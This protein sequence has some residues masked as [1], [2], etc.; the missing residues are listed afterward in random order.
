ME[1]L[2]AVAT[3]LG[4]IAAVWYFWDKGAERWV[5]R[6]APAAGAAAAPAQTAPAPRSGIAAVLHAELR[7]FGVLMGE[8]VAAARAAV[9]RGR[10]VLRAAMTEFGGRLAPAAADAILAVFDDAARC[11]ACAVAA[12]AALARANAVLPPAERVHYRFGIDLREGAAADGSPPRAAVERAA[13]IGLRAPTDGIRLTEAVRA[14][15]PDD[16]GYGFSAVE[17]GLFALDDRDVPTPRPGPPQLESLAL[18]L[19]DRPSTLLLPFGCAG[20]D[21]D[22]TVLADGLRLDIQNAL[23]KMSGV[24]QIA[25]GTGNALPGAEGIEAAR[26]VG[27][28]TSSRAPS[29]ATA[30][31][32]G[33]AFSLLTR[34]PERSSGPRS[35][36][37]CSITRSSCRTRSPR[38]WS[39]RST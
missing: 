37:G 25:A 30:S 12:R 10:D 22:G 34:S 18:P 31:A 6:K 11:V 16:A 20:E 33:S 28:G 21:P 23:V 32:S 2:L 24:F 27:S 1:V 29:S 3:L 19:P 39:P 8:D 35:T 13:A 17:P 38:A 14:R 9:A 4:G 7:A 5:G 26:R 36:T 15:L